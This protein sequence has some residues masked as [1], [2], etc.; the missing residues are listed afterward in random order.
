MSCN[1]I[2]V[3]DPAFNEM[4]LDDSFENRRITLAVPGTFWVHDGNR[5][6]LA[7]AQAIR[8]GPEDAALFGKLQLLEPPLQEVP[9]GEGAIPVAA[10]RIRL[11]AAEEDVTPRDVHADRSGTRRHG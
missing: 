8:L 6:S 7:D 3:H 1:Q 11:I 2:L 4:F 9:R 5:P 10:F